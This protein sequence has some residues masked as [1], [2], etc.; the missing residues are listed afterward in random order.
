MCKDLPFVELKGR[1]DRGCQGRRM[2]RRVGGVIVN[3]LD[4]NT[5]EKIVFKN[6]T[7][8]A[9]ELNISLRTVSRWI[10]YFILH[11]I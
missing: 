9:K 3:L 4:V 10:S 6:K 5:S 2:E 1:R 8:V 7:L 11:I